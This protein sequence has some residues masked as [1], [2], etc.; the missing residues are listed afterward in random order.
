[1]TNLRD[2]AAA[3]T[4]AKLTATEHVRRVLADLDA[5]DGTPW[6]NIVAARDDAA[7]LESAARADADI[8]A[9]NWIGPLHGIAIA[10]KDN[11]DVAGLP[12]RCGS[13][14]LADAPAADRDARIVEKLR[15]AGAII[16]AKTH[17]HEFAYGP[18][19]LVNASGPAAHPHNPALISG[20]SSSGSAVLVAKGIV[21][22]AVGT[23]TGCSVR[24]PAALCGIAGFKP[25]SGALPL[26][27][28][29]PRSTT[30]DHVGLLT[31]DSLDAA[32]AW[33][34]VPGVAHLRSP[35]SGLRVG[36][37]RG[38]IWDLT[39]PEFDAAADIA[40]RTLTDLGTLMASWLEGNLKSW[41]GEPPRP[42]PAEGSTD[43]IPPP[44]PRHPHNPAYRGAVGGRGPRRATTVRQRPF[45]SMGG[46]HEQHQTRELG[47]PAQAPFWPLASPIPRT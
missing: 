25:S 34:A 33:G 29:F 9:G 23:D 31:T 13:N 45:E 37:L 18:T 16:V 15:E 41:A 44:P 38:G 46:H 4:A 14:V 27:G 12:T 8:A 19:G 20:G 22:V 3:L 11:I 24:T 30:F 17:M 7:A 39:D 2:T 10:V 35:V 43:G 40:C 32:L 6:S 28:I 26:D 21:P 36:R 5:L 47:E 42:G 1:M